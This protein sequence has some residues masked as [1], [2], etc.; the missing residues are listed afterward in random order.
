VRRLVLLVCIVSLVVAPR[1]GAA[2]LDGVP[3]RGM[4]LGSASAPLRVEWY[5]DLQCPWCRR[6]DQRHLPGV[7]RRWV[8]PGR[9]R[10]VYRPLAFLGRDSVRLAR[11]VAAAGAQDR[12]W[13]AVDAVFRTQGPE[14][15]GWATDAYLA[16][17]GAGIGGFDVPRALAERRSPAVLRL[18]ERTADRARRRRV[19]STP[20][21]I[22][23]RRG[24]PQRTGEGDPGLERAMAALALG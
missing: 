10:L 22:V 23:H 6:F 19:V 9:A 8:R 24:R 18:I 1:A 20:T 16:G 4:T 21:F 3:Q 14:G 12:A 5:A 11:F 17:V 15:G 13:S 2:E 7:L